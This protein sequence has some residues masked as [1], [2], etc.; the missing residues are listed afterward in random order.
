MSMFFKVVVFKLFTTSKV[1]LSLN[2]LTNR[3]NSI[4][5]I[6]SLKLNTEIPLM[7]NYL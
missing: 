1:V 6:I 7:I 5:K 3:N 2:C 4:P